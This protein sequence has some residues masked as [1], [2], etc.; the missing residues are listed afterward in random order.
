MSGSR[1][2]DKALTE[3]SPAERARWGC[4]HKGTSHFLASA[5]MK[6]DF[7]EPFSPTKKVTGARK[8][9]V[10]RPARGGMLNG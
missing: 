4:P 7:P 8:P 1:Y 9:R 5:C 3:T 2:S 10:C 6:V